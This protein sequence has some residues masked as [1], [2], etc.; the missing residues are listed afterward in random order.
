MKNKL[1]T[2]GE[3]LAVEFL[4]N[5]GYKIIKTNWRFIHKEI[6]IIAEKDGLLVF[7]E[8]KSR[9]DD[10]YE[11]PQDAVSVKKQRFLLEAAEAYIEKY[12]IHQEA[13]FDII[14]IIRKENTVN[15]EHIEDAF[16]SLGV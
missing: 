8:V 9:S 15:L 12:D 1:G 10:F 14:A 2:F 6:D 5:K 11:N 3:Q 4:M 13:R 16:N 7:V